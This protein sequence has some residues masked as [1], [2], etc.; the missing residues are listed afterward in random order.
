LSPGVDDWMVDREVLPFYVTFK[1]AQRTDSAIV[2][3]SARSTEASVHCSNG[4][5][6][7]AVRQWLPVPSTDAGC[8]FNATSVQQVPALALES[9]YASPQGAHRRPEGASVP[10]QCSA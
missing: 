7:T 2:T 10:V 6:G 1:S 3:C 4:A 5:A 9:G 8:T